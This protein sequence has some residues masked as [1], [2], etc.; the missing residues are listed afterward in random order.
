MALTNATIS[1]TATTI[2]DVDNSGGAALVTI[3][4]LN[5]DSSARS[6]TVH[7]RPGGEAVANENTIFTV[8]IPAGESYVFNDKLLLSD[9]DIISAL[10][11]TASVVVATASYINL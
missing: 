2:L 4:L 7:A 11:D 6:V 9:N 10:A 1:D 5:T 3:I 8:S